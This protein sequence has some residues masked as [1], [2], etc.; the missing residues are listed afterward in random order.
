MNKDKVAM[1]QE[2]FRSAAGKEV[3]KDLAQF[4]LVNQPTY[5]IGDPHHSAFN[6]G[7]R[8]V[9]L[10][11]QSFINHQEVVDGESGYEHGDS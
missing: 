10:R 9:Y 6:E 1:Y 5:V 11:V 3:L 4:C 2:C 7:M 8:R